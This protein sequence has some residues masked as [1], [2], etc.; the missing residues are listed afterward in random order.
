MTNLALAAL[1]LLV[2]AADEAPP[3]APKPLTY[4]A[5][6][7]AV[8]ERE[9]SFAQ[10]VANHDAKAFAEHVHPDAAFLPGPNAVVRGRAAVAAD[11]AGLIAGGDVELQWHPQLVAIAGDP[12]TAISQGPYWFEDTRPDAKQRFSMGRFNSVWSRGADGTWHVLFDG[13]GAPARPASAEE[14]DKLKASLAKEC[15]R[16]AS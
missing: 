8:W 10:S 14:I 6:E 13:G 3:P 2:A 7:C 12:D 9:R 1:T 15:P 11:W 4:S 5:D 16:A